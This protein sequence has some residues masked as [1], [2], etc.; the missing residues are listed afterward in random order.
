MSPERYADTQ[1]APAEAWADVDA[2]INERIRQEEA[3]FRR[4]A[5]TAVLLAAACV[6]VCFAARCFVQN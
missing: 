2:D 6:A 1:P 5:W 3:A 4:E